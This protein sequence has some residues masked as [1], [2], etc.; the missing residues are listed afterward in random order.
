[1]SPDDI[2]RRPRLRLTVNGS[3]I[4]CMSAEITSQRGSH[5]ATFRRE[6]NH[7]ILSPGSGSSWLDVDQIEV[8]VDIGFA[9][10]G[11]ALP[12]VWTSMVSGIV[13]RVSLDPVLSLAVLDGRD[14]AARLI[15]LPLQD[16]YLNK[17]GA[18]VARDL[19]SR[20]GLAADVDDTAGLVGQYYQIQHSKT[21]FG[22]YSRHANGWDLLSELAEI[23]NYELWVDGRTLHFKRPSQAGQPLAVSF[24]PGNAG[25]SFP[26][27]NVDTLSLDRTT[28]LSGP[29]QVGID[30]WNSRQKQRITAR[31]PVSVSGK[32][33]LYTIL[34]PNLQAEQADALAKA[35]YLQLRARKRTLLAT[36]AG[37]LTLTPRRTLQ[38][39]GTGTGWDTV[40]IVDRIVRHI[41]LQR[42]FTQHISA[43][44]LEDESGSD[45]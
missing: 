22:A 26:V 15:D 12:T 43:V 45:E 23:E 21:V 38:M 42:G 5:A 20:C 18:E 16:A 34:K 8:V 30:S 40:Y 32:V 35:A 11:A 37:E 31:Y 27:L 14:Y 17:T 2:V 29:V 7:N 25:G 36:M 41:C 3:V 24:G 33:R 19:A 6:V 28:G 44:T 10:Q 9:G 13:D 1:M 39:T 4:A